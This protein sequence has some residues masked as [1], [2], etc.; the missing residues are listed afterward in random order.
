MGLRYFPAA[1]NDIKGALLWSAENF[2]NLAAQR[3]K[4]LINTVIDE[5]DADQE[6]AGSREVEGLQAGIRIYHLKHSRMRAAVDGRVVK[7]PRHFIA[8]K[9]LDGDTVIVRLLHD[10]MN[11]KQRLKKA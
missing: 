10:R 1:R 11:L 7:K 5:I 9:V 6:L 3:Y 2:G 8:Y 4:K